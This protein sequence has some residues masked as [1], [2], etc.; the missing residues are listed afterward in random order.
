MVP[1]P[2]YMHTNCTNKMYM[3]I[4]KNGL[5]ESP[6]CTSYRSR[7]YQKLALSEFGYHVILADKTNSLLPIAERRACTLLLGQVHH[8]GQWD[9]RVTAHH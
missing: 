6:I 9:D 5:F 3:Y 8:P 7:Q 4:D 1:V 2:E